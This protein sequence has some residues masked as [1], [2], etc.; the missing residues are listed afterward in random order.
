MSYGLKLRNIRLKFCATVKN[1][2]MAATLI[3][4]LISRSFELRIGLGTLHRGVIKPW[5]SDQLL[6]KNAQTLGKIRKE[7]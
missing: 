5:Q 2:P 1:A 3:T 7:I 4:D 6:M